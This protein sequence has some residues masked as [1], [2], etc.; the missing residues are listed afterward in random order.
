LAGFSPMLF[1]GWRGE[2]ICDRPTP[3]NW[4]GVLVFA[5]VVT[6]WDESSTRSRSGGNRLWPCFRSGLRLRLNPA[7]LG[8]PSAAPATAMLSSKI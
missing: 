7:V 8:H 2:F 4:S 3:G 6:A 1:L 5:S